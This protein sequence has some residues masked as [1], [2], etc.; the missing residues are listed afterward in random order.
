[1][2]KMIASILI[3]GISYFYYVRKLDDD[4]MVIIDVVDYEKRS[5]DFYEGLFE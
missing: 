5:S 1:M 4:L 3:S 2:K